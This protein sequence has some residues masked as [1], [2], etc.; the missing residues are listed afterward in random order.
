M[1]SDQVS[2]NVRFVHHLDGAA[3]DVWSS[4]ETALGGESDDHVN[5]KADTSGRVFAVVKNDADQVK[6]LVR[7]AAG[8]WSRYL[9]APGSDRFTRP[10]LLLDEGARRVHVFAAGQDSGDIHVKSSSMDVVS[11][12]SGQGIVM[13]RDSSNRRLNNPT[14][15]K[16]LVNSRTG[17][18]VLAAHETS[19]R[20]WYNGVPGVPRAAFAAAP[21]RGSAPLVVSFTDTSTGPVTAWLW[22]FG[23]GT[24]SSLQSPTHLYGAGTFSVSLTVTGPGGSDTD[25]RSDLI[26]AIPPP[27]VS[28]STAV[29]TVASPVTAFT[30]TG[31]GASPREKD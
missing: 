9:V 6:L 20:Y 18:V 22:S 25:I 12:P 31:A 1:W 8:G 3:D 5:M 4:V 10:I 2:N 15:T 23:D 19:E 21:E 29:S 27:P 30:G 16:A 17:V 28:A 24:T 13:I 14:S 7:G 26:V 11:F